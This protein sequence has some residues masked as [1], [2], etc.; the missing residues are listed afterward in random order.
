MV[1]LVG[2]MMPF[3]KI[4]I[5]I[6]LYTSLRNDQFQLYLYEIVSSRGNDKLFV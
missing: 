5:Y 4:F 3:M 6:K 1:H 2:H